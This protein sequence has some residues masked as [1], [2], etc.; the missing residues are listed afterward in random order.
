MAEENGKQKPETDFRSGLVRATVW[1]NTRKDRD[2]NE[3][4]AVSVK[5]EKALPLSSS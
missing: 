1:K 2:G 3:F 5:V 4:E